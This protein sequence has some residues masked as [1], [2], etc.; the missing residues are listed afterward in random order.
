[1][2]LSLLLL[3]ARVDPVSPVP[4]GALIL[5][6]AI[7]FVFMNDDILV[8]DPF[9]SRVEGATRALNTG[10]IFSGDLSRTRLTTVARWHPQ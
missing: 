9:D 1:M 4:W 8:G 2:S 6:L 3:D 5:L 7:V 10:R